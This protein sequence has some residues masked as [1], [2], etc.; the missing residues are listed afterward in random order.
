MQWNNC[1]R[2]INQK[3]GVVSTVA[4]DHK[5]PGAFDGEGSKASFALPTGIAL[6]AHGN[7]VRV[8]RSLHSISDMFLGAE[9]CTAV[10]GHSMCRSRAVTAFAK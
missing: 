8:L 4:G 1:I 6:D 9:R 10:C 2:K 5:Y 3:T 7:L